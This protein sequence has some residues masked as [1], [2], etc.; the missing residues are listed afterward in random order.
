MTLRRR[1]T[2]YLLL[3]YHWVTIKLCELGLWLL[4]KLPSK[5]GIR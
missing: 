1:I 5:P 3:A 2:I 4:N